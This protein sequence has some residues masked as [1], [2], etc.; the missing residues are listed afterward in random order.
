MP[1]TP[2][3]LGAQQRNDMD[4]NDKDVYKRIKEACANA[5]AVNRNVRNFFAELADNNYIGEAK[6]G[7]VEYGGPD[8]DPSEYD[9]MS[10]MLDEI[11]AFADTRLAEKTATHSTPPRYICHKEVYAHKI[12][13]ITKYPQRD[14]WVNSRAGHGM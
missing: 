8:F 9:N 12:K 1:I 4:L 5:A 13:S 3:H 2:R 11:V 14:H 10:R 7:A 6:G